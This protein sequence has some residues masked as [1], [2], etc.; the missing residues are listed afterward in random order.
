MVVRHTHRW[1]KNM[2]MDVKEIG[3]YSVE[4]GQHTIACS[5]VTRNSI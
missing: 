5:G 3:W 4:W 1:A 2:K